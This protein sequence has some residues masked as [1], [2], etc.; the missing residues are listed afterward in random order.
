MK[1]PS[2][3]RRCHRVRVTDWARLCAQCSRALDEM[4][5]RRPPPKEEPGG[6]TEVSDPESGV[7]D[8]EPSSEPVLKPR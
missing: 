5:K 3:C 8:P 4:G 7:S 2:I 1:P 6:D